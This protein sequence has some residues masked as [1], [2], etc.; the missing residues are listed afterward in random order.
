N[1][2]ELTTAADVYSL[3]AILYEL[4]MGRPPFKCDNVLDTLLQVRVEKPKSPRSLNARVDADL[5]TI[6]LKCLEKEPTKRYASAQ[7]L[8]DDL[9]RLI[10]GEPVGARPVGR[11]ERAWRWCR[12]NP[13]VA[14][15]LALV[16][17]SLV[18]GTTA[19]TLFAVAAAEQ[20]RVAHEKAE[21][22]RQGER[23]A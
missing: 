12:R 21:A 2:R 8:A 1:H 22:A 18:T 7:E 3:G 10:E 4:L 6:C 11:L 20:A 15:L 17:L 9:Q 13:A 14:S 19:S 16:T 23:L 5:E